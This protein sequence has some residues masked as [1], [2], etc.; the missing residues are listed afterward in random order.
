[1]TTPREI[2][3]IQVADPHLGANHEHHLDNWRKIVAWV[4]RAA[5]A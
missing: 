2:R 1:M 5:G 4:A 3:L